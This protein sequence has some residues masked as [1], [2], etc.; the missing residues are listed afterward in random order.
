MNLSINM[1]TQNADEEEKHANKKLIRIYE[2]LFYKGGDDLRRTSVLQLE[3]VLYVYIHRKDNS[4][5]TRNVII[6]K[7]LIL[8]I[9]NILG[10]LARA[11]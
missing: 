8:N 3:I 9:G 11:V 7:F 2:D 4:T 1:L 5:I 10:K 6:S